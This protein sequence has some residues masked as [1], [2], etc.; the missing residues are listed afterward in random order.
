MPKYKVHFEINIHGDAFVRAESLEE[1]RELAKNLNARDLAERS[2]Y[3]DAA[4]V[5]RI[6]KEIGT[7]VIESRIG[8]RRM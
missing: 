5:D 3:E 4:Y 6:Y 8:T 7:E 1:A 2:F